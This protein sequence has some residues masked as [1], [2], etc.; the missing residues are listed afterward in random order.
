MKFHSES[1]GIMH[2]QHDCKAIVRRAVPNVSWRTGPAAKWTAFVQVLALALIE[3]EFSKRC[4]PESPKKRAIVFI[5]MVSNGSLQVLGRSKPLPLRPSYPF[6]G[7]LKTTRFSSPQL[8]PNLTRGMRVPKKCR[9]VFSSRWRWSA[10]FARGTLFACHA[11][12][13]T[14]S[15]AGGAG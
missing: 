9:S 6:L 11:P 10:N 2:S 12:N 7:R 4:V 15:C 1:K 13:F 8:S 3:S 5:L 14:S